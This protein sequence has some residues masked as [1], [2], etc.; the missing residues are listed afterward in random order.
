MVC[1]SEGLNQPSLRSLAV[2][3]RAK[4]YAAEIFRALRRS[5]T[6]GRNTPSKDAIH[7]S[8][9]K[10]LLYQDCMTAQL[11]QPSTGAGRP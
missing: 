3:P 11:S 6:V 10:K 8:L 2:E 7:A 5:I 9:H 4:A 1:T